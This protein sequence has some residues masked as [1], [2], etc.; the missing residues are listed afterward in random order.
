MLH[1]SY[2]RKR[3]IVKHTDEDPIYFD[4]YDPQ[5]LREILDAQQQTN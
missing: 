1:G 3:M 5:A 4:H 2:V